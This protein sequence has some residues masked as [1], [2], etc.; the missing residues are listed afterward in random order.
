MLVLQMMTAKV[1]FIV[2]LIWEDHIEKINSVCGPKCV[3]ALSITCC[4]TNKILSLSLFFFLAC[5]MLVPQ[6]GTEPVVSAMKAQS[7]KN[8][9]PGKSQ[10]WCKLFRCQLLI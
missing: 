4:A 7:P 9:T 8:W 3:S 1:S 10:L 5:G 2:G 6:P